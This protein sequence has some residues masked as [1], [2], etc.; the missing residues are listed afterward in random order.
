MCAAFLLVKIAYLPECS[1]VRTS[2]FTM[3]RNSSKPGGKSLHHIIPNFSTPTATHLRLP[4]H[5]LQFSPHLFTPPVAN[6]WANSDEATRSPLKGMADRISSLC[7]E[8]ACCHF[9]CSNVVVGA[10]E[11][12]IS[13][14]SPPLRAF[15]HLP[16]IAPR[17]AAAIF[18]VRAIP[19]GCD[20]MSIL[21][22]SSTCPTWRRIKKCDISPERWAEPLLQL[23]L[24]SIICIRVCINQVGGGML[25]ARDG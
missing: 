19:L 1:A 16:E 6:L 13:T 11:K 7:F 21:P 24:V 4:P 22:A 10:V 18:N 17:L 5:S 8:L 20:S 23:I 2:R 25:I 9:T 12:N 15:A 14:K 3:L